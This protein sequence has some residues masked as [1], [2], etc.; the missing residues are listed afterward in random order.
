MRRSSYLQRNSRTS[1]QL[2]NVTRRLCGGWLA[3]ACCV[4]FSGA[5]SAGDT[6][7]VDFNRDIRPILSDKCYACHGPDSGQREAELRFD[8]ESDALLDRGGYSAILPKN[9]DESE[10]VARI[11]SEDEDLLMPPPTHPKALSERE[12]S[13]LVR[14]IAAGAKW[15]PHWSYAPLNS[16]VSPAVDPNANDLATQGFIDSYV[17]SKLKALDIEPSSP[18]EPRTLIRRLSLDLIGLPPDSTKVEAFAEDPSELQY[19]ESVESLL[20]SPHFGERMA[21]YWLDLVRYADT[22]GYH[23]DQDVSVSPYRDYVI[24]AFNGNKPFDEFTREQLAGDLLPD[25]TQEDLV[26]SGYNKLGMMSAEGGVQPEEYLAKYAADRVRTAATIWLGSTLG[27]AECHDHKFDPFTAKDFYQFAAFFAD[28][29]ERGLYS[30]ANRDGNWGPYVRV[31]D[32]GIE[33]E[34]AAFDSELES[35]NKQ[36][37]DSSPARLQARRKWE[38]AVLRSL[39]AWKPLSP[40][41]ATALEASLSVLDDG[42]VLANGTSPSKETYTLKVRLKQPSHALRIRVLPDDSL[43]QKGP[44]R[45]GNG[46]FVITEVRLKAVGEKVEAEES[47]AADR[48]IQVAVPI[49]KAIADHEQA[50]AS[51]ENP[52]GKWAAAATVDSDEHGST[53]GWAVLPKVGQPHSLVLQFEELLPA[54]EYELEIEQ[55]HDN[56]KHTLGKF[57]LAVAGEPVEFED[58]VAG[59]IEDGQLEDEV[60]AALRRKADQRSLDDDAML[61]AAFQEL[62]PEL[63]GLRSKIAE[64]SQARQGFFESHS[65]STLVTKSVDPREVRVLNRGDWMDKSGEAVQPSVPH[66]LPQVP[67]G[68]E[69]RRLNRLDLANWIASPENPLT[70]RVFVNRIWKLFFGTGLSK[71]LDDFGSQGESPTHPEL[72]D[73]LA[74]EFVES[75][76]DVKHLVRLIVLSETYRQSSMPR[77][78]LAEIDPYNRLLA[79]QSRF[80]MDAELIR[81][82]AL[83]VSGL[84]VRQVGGRSAKPYQPAGLLR[85]LNFPKREYQQDDGPNQYRR[86]LY[87]HWQRQFLHPAMQAFDAPA[88]EECTAE[89]PRSNTPLAALVLLNDPSYVEAARRFAEQALLQSLKSDEERLN[90]MIHEALSRPARDVELKSLRALIEEER[91]GFAA[92]PESAEAFIGT[93]LSEPEASVDSVELAA[94]TSASRV[95]LNLHET[96]TR[97]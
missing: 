7:E 48:S 16:S 44:G 77:P 64:V 83:S 95:L 13:L 60:V 38:Q 26:A 84:L 74:L 34:L 45:A 40:L 3:L 89:R 79:R 81:D 37:H 63:A 65:R 72:L 54:G 23:G 76:W 32:R 41:E 85:H 50:D 58:A 27:C 56:P 14:W 94:W 67:T 20:R 6:S 35:L 47:V 96:I 66:F 52:F 87:T 28:I 97:N 88:R 25:P 36:L 33:E 61:A 11:Y 91:S 18:A 8:R 10:L 5:L 42:S 59:L 92:N 55:N 73:R 17:R 51:K 78:E 53:W 24:N 15:A 22:V 86:G 29:K 69:S 75:G 4:P 90:W 30:G 12:K 19:T 62:S 31:A 43:P 82:Q 49:V 57:Q 9:P 2:V 68:Q 93:G 71:T 70:A 80:R 46:N 21:I 1:G 39:D